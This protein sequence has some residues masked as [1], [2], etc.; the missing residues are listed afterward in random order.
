MTKTIAFSIVFFFVCHLGFCQVERTILHTATGDIFG[1]L[2]LPVKNHHIPVVLLIAGSGPTDRDG[3]NPVM[4]NNSLKMLAE[5]LQ[6][7]GIATLRFDK[8]GIG[9]SGNAMKKESDLR[10]EDYV[11]DVKEWIKLL[12]K[13]R[14]FTKVIVAGHSEGSLIGMIAVQNEKKVAK[15]ISISG[16]GQCADTLLKEQLS[17]QPTELKLSVYSM[18]DSLKHGDTLTNVPSM[19]YTLFRPSVQPYMISWFKYDPQIE[20]KKVTI[21]ILIIQGTKDIQ[22]SVH[23]ADLLSAAVPASEKCI[24]EDM[25]HVLKTSISTDRSVQIKT[26]NDPDLPLNAELVYDIVRFIK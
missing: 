26:Y 3:N 15:F 25:N 21:P 22:V 6:K 12:S 23:Q 13:D 14:R 19:L 4:K 24:I 10:F 8:R 1:T 2:L 11:K 16:A 20:I 7:A 5:G 18:I 9:E 17:S